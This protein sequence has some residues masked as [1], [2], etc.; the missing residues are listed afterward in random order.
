MKKKYVSLAAL[1]LTAILLCGCGGGATSAASAPAAAAPAMDKAESTLMYTNGMAEEMGWAEPE[2]PRE[3][4]MTGGTIAGSG[5]QAPEGAKRIYT[6][7]L[8]LETTEFDRAASELTALVERCG[9]YF[10]NSSVGEYGGGYRN[11][12]YVVRVPAEQF[13]TF[14]N[15]VGGLCHVTWQTSSCED[16]SEYYYDTAGRLETQRTKLE[17]L[18]E[19]LSRAESMEDIITIESAISQTE[20]N[21]ERLA[22]ELQHYDALVA[23]STVTLSLREVYRLSNT[24]EPAEGFGDRVGKAFGSGWKNFTGGMED[25]A[26]S[27]AY[28]WVWVL[29]W[30]AV[31][32]TAGTTVIRRRRRKKA[33]QQR[34]QEES[35]G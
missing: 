3:D 17:R 29:V 7:R 27:L 34:R 10:Q 24:E 6:A 9:G 20:E 21:I 22:G 16:V 33:E 11:A 23:Y 18:Q 5:A 4:G 8:E 13:Q 12:D 26:I 32:V 25:L 28:S 30:L 2:A 1:F 19:L 14:L 31:I 15:E 35:G